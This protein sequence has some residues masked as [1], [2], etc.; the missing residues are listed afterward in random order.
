[1]YKC[2]CT[3]I[4]PPPSPPPF[5]IPYFSG[6]ALRMD[7][8]MLRNHLYHYIYIWMDKRGFW[9]YPTNVK[10]N[11]MEGYSWNK[12]LWEHVEFNHNNIKEI[13]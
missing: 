8:R 6:R 10:S 5:A 12:G 9:F 7:D 2:E 4:M 13:Y 11:V 3:Y 1:M